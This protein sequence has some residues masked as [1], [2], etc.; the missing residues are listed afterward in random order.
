MSRHVGTTSVRRRSLL[1]RYAPWLLLSAAATTGAAIL[2]RT[3]TDDFERF[4]GPSPPALTVAAAGL[5]GLGAL[6]FL[7]RRGFWRDAC[8][9]RTLRGVAVATLASLPFAALAIAAD[10]IGGFPRDTNVAWPGAWLFYPSV[11]VVAE[12]AFHL[13]SLAG[14]MALTGTRLTGRA[15]DR[16]AAALIAP[17]AAVEPVA[18]VALGS[19]LPGFT[20]V[21]V[22]LI[23]LVQLTLLRRFGYVPMLW[24]RL[25]YY[26]SW[27]ILWGAARLELRF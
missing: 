6:W 22:Y 16:R 2:A 3:G 23:G 15:I 12:T 17:V 27:H 20:A 10:L 1:R 21:H 11:L 24:F 9:A 4:L 25:C 7:E 8:L 14:L 18:Q 5:A 26:L 19:A 13:L